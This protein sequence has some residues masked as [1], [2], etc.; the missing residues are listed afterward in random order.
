MH[1]NYPY[2]TNRGLNTVGGS[3]NGNQHHE[4]RIEN[5]L[6][7]NRQQNTAGLWNGGQVT[8]HT[9]NLV[10]PTGEWR[11]PIFDLRPD[12][13]FLSQGIAEASPV[14]RSKTGD[15]GSLWVLIDGLNQNFGGGL[16]FAGL[17][18]RYQEK[19]SPIDPTLIRNVNDPIDITGEFAVNTTLPFAEQQQG[20]LL[21]FKPTSDVDP[22]RYWQV[23]IYFDWS[24]TFTKNVQLRAQSSYY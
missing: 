16:G 17:R 20:A 10:N 4:T 15:W 19:A 18:V 7:A 13:P 3:P 23:V 6:V 21:Q 14:Y 2:G 12:L 8:G 1:W 9:S 11:S 5:P 22:V 24:F